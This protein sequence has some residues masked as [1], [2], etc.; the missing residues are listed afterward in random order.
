MHTPGPHLETL[1]HRLAD[2]PVEFLSEPR[3][4][5][6]ANAQAVAVAALVNDILLLHGARAPAASLQGFQG[7]HVKADRNRLALVMILCWLLADEWFIGQRLAQ[8]DLLQVLGEAAR[9]LAAATPAH[10]FTQDPERR[11]ELARI[12]LAR[13]GFRPRDESV[14]Q[15]TD[16]LSAISGTER[17]RLLEASR[18]A[19]Q[20]A[21]EIREALA[22][23][24]AEESA[25]KWSRE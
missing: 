3:I 25:D 8:H 5:G 11:E 19:E 10:Q 17:R 20:R 14:A 16:R 1:T 12:V 13:L 6:V 7:A 9:E 18:L 22:K 2:T 21:R 15:S 24:A 4:A 23:K